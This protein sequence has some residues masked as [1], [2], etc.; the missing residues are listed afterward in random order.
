MVRSP[1]SRWYAP[2][3]ASITH[4]FLVKSAHIYDDSGIVQAQGPQ[5]LSEERAPVS[6]PT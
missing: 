5:R 3:N 2:L 1:F 4:E 6:A